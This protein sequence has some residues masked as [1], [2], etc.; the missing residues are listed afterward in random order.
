VSAERARFMHQEKINWSSLR[1]WAWRAGVTLLALAITIIAAFT[2]LVYRSPYA[3]L[4]VGGAV[5]AVAILVV[6]FRR[7]TWMLYM[8]LF[9]ILFPEGLLP[10]SIQSLLNRMITVMAVASWL[11]D[12]VARRRRIVWTAAMLFMFAF[13]VWSALT[14][15]W[16]R[17]L[18]R[19]LTI[20]QTYGLRFLLFMLVVPNLVRTE[21]DLDG[22]MKTLA[23]S[24]RVLVGVAIIYV[25]V[26]GFESGQRLRISSVN[27][28]E[29]GTLVL[30]MLA[31][32][33]W[34]AVRAGRKPRIPTLV[35]TAA[36][37]LLTIIVVALSGSRGGA[38]SLVGVLLIFGLC[39]PTR[40]WGVLGIVILVLGVLVAPLL[41]ATT[42]ERFL[43]TRGDTLL[44]GREGLW[45]GAWTLITERVWRGVGIGNGP[46]EVV[47]YVVA[48]R[49]IR[50]SDFAPIHNP[51]LT[52]WAETGIPGLL[53]YLLVLLS[54]FL[55]FVRCFLRYRRW[56]S[57]ALR[58]YF[59]LTSAVFG[60]FMLSWIKG[61]GMETEPAYFMV[62]AL[63]LIPAN[64]MIASENGAG[65]G[66][67]PGLS[68]AM[69]LRRAQ[70]D[71][72]V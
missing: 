64:L 54:S 15:S 9:L 18:N 24:G 31:G 11:F 23:M 27:E 6:V 48:Y 70:R 34:Q 39:R 50:G 57:P 12:L 7:P 55:S 69:D 56:A 58:A 2:G 43:L 45:R 59:A 71:G 5:V 60:G 1:P 36:S 26:V 63:L 21:E 19:G 8:T 67:S 10:A 20:L 30:V 29:L 44:G 62:L 28:N 49:S 25:L 14:L 22:L 17:D 68:Q 38:I 16:A 32:V 41:F 42:A 65:Q 72:Q 4:V 61:G 37:L 52:I 51:V 35:A 47:P 3:P 40:W 33:L 13:V 66:P 46:Y 53:L